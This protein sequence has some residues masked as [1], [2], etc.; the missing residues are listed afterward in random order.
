M[1]FNEIYF[2]RCPEEIDKLIRELRSSG[3]RVVVAYP[4]ITHKD[5]VKDNVLNHKDNV[6]NSILVSPRH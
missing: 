1:V 2:D 5:N 3:F 4:P 6:L